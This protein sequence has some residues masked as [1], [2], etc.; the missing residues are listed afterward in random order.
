MTKT[1]H[2]YPKNSLPK[3]PDNIFPQKNSLQYFFV[4][5]KP[6]NIFPQK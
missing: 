6:E 5:K 1:I 2:K 3:I 4:K